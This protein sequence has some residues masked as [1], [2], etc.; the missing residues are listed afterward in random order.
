VFE[1]KRTEYSEKKKMESSE[2]GKSEERMK[3]SY[4]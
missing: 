3:K 1:S 4:L 2:F